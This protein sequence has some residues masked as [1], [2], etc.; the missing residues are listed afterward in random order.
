[1]RTGFAKLASLWRSLIRAL[2]PWARARETAPIDSGGERGAELQLRERDSDVSHSGRTAGSKIRATQSGNFTVAQPPDRVHA[3]LVNPA[4]F[5]N[6]IPD[7]VEHEFLDDGEFRIVWKVGAGMLKTTATVNMRLIESRPGEF[8]CY[9]GTG[10]IKERPLKLV[11][12][13]R[14]V[15]C[16]AGTEIPW[17]GEMEVQ[18]FA[19]AFKNLLEPVALI[20]IRK[21]VS[22]VQ[23]ALEAD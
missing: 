12:S 10:G 17:E 3:F 21:L 19:P 16:D 8:V 2:T 20:N 13:F 5:V 22:R 14:L 23:G 18:G 1:M 9:S 4:Q 7:L 15:E 6:L 11:A